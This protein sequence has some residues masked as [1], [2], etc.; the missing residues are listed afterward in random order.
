MY[1]EFSKIDD[2]I[3][4]IS[5]DKKNNRFST[6][7]FNRYPIRFVLFDN[8]LDS[9]EFITQSQ[10]KYNCVVK[11]IDEWMDPLFNDIIITHFSFSNFIDDYIKNNPSIDSIIAPFS[12]L[13]RFYNNINSS[14]FDSLIGT[15]KSVETTQ[16]GFENNQRIYIPIVGLEGKMSR[17]YD[18]S[19]IN[20]WYCKNNIERTNYR[21][22]FS[23]STYKV[24]GLDDE[25]YVVETMQN[26]LKVWKNK[27]V[28]SKIISISNSLY[29]NSCFAQPDNSFD[30]ITCSNVYDFLTLGLGL[31]FGSVK[32]SENEEQFW[33]RLASEIDIKNFSF[34]KFINHYFHIDNLTDL[35]VFLKIWFECKDEFD[36]WILFKYYDSKFFSKGYL[37]QILK[38]VKNLTNHEFFSV[39]ALSIFNMEEHESIINERAFCLQ[40]AKEKNVKLNENVQNL[41]RDK[42]I[43]ISILQGYNTAIRYFSPLTN[44]E[45]SLAIMWYASGK[46][47]LDDV[48]KFF[49]E[50][51][52]YLGKSFG[53]SLKWVLDYI[54]V[55]KI[56]KIKN[57]YL[58]QIKN[59][60]NNYN[61]STVSFYTWYQD[62]KTVK[63]VF[64]N[65]N[66]IEVFFWI[67]GLGIDWIPYISELINKNSEVFLN[68]VYIAHSLLPS[69][70][71]NNKPVLIEL[72]EEP[73]NK[74]ADLDS[75]SH[76][77][78]NKYPL[79][80]IEEFEI[81]K[82]AINEILNEFSGK[83]IAIISDHGLTAL[84]QFKDGLNLAGVSSDHN[85]R[86]G[87]RKTGKSF[88]D[89]NYI[90][91][92]DNK[93]MCALKHMSLC[94]KIPI[95]QSAHGGCTPEEVLVPILIISSKKATVNW[96]AELLTFEIS[97]INPVVKYKIKG[98]DNSIAP[99]IIYNNKRYELNSE[100]NEI[101]VSDS[102]FLSRNDST[103]S[104]IIGDEKIVNT[105]NIKLGVEEDDLLDF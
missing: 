41:L 27:D 92:E 66:D 59:Y 93:T 36:K 46:I 80:I 100:Q 69:T 103:I 34:D 97:T 74:I 61:D 12:E 4:Y 6:N 79:Y 5:I 78:G 62:F 44:A 28:K 39:I 99:Y 48:K 53:T 19:Q 9:F 76:K 68:E 52:Y 104:L 89:N 45:K 56:A 75:H 18:D 72:S 1:K 90:I 64:S 84:S 30:F 21:L 96:K 38:E 95:G 81:V 57:E 101:F 98:L 10:S 32:Y 16:I 105:L 29:A 94:G 7:L 31:N 87:I 63:T 67:D 65:R 85:G 37:C 70:T 25:Y 15:I 24:K 43:N 11:S 22:I 20:I 8:F 13:A 82:D 35:N 3:E 86:I 26:W 88:S 49:P 17:F 55:Y 58:I 2:L 40:F 102:I 23:Q 71:E 33:H 51:D 77:Q 73:L 60:I 14:E 91:L 54:D 83:K 42:L 50:M 47:S